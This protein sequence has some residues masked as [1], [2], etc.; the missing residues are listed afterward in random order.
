MAIPTVTNF[1]TTRIPVEG[2]STF[3]ADAS[4]VW[5][6]IP[7]VIDSMNAAIVEQNNVSDV[8]TLSEINAKT[9]ETNAATSE[10]NAKTSETNASDSA[11][12]ASAAVASLPAGT[13]DDLLI[14]TDKAWSSDKINREISSIDTSVINRPSITSP[15]DGAVDFNGDIASSPYTSSS[16]YKGTH[17]GTDWEVTTDSTFAVIDHSSYNDTVNLTQLHN[18]ADLATTTYYVRCRYI[19]DSHTSTWSTPV[20]F[21]TSAVYISTPVVTVDGE[22]TSV[23]ET[24]YFYGGAFTV[25]G[26]TDT[27]ISTDWVVKD[28]NGLVVWQSLGDTVNLTSVQVPSGVLLVSTTYTFEVTYYGATYTSTLGSTSA[29]T[30]ASFFIEGI[31]SAIITASDGLASDYF[32][33]GISV[34]DDGRTAVVGA[35]VADGT[36]LDEG[37][38]YIYT[39]DGTTVTE[40][41]ILTSPDA[42]SADGYRFGR[43]VCISKDGS[44]IIVYTY[45]YNGTYLSEGKV[46]I[47]TWDGITATYVTSVVSPDAPVA[48]YAQ[49]GNFLSL[50]YD[51]STLLIGEPGNDVLATD[52]GAVHLFSFDGTNTTSL[53]TIRASDGAA[54]DYFG[55]SGGISDAGST[56]VVGAYTADTANADQGKAYIF[57]WDGT[58]ATEKV[59][60]TASDGAASDYF[61]I[62]SEISGD[63]STV[64]I[65]AYGVDGTYLGEGKVYIYTWDGTTVTE[66]ATFSGSRAAIADNRYLGYSVSVNYSGDT[67]LIS[68]HTSDYV[69][70]NQGDAYICS[71]DG[72]TLTET[73]VINSS[74]GATGDY[75]SRDIQISN[76][77]TTAWIGAYGADTAN[78]DQGKVYIF[79]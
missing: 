39:W 38:V 52:A 49:F 62:S 36:Y 77:G 15:A 45:G 41:A 54:S 44:T 79:V 20:S 69:T 8:V 56:I 37:K 4:Y 1:D 63:S 25:N 40:A 47:Y 53:T 71:W 78:V 42:I 58:T 32:G 7:T 43:K 75:F 24:P 6:T 60:L 70:V 46:Y 26:G 23:G 65:G 73:N 3:R 55:A 67:I 35:Y 29:T 33:L 48:D 16:T 61:G 21:T 57:T 28:S 51:G 66:A 10:A 50:N 31:E 9:S 11:D 34:S 30:R 18:P 64:V 12:I 14:A 76:D 59:I 13:I 27:H 2:S 74:D 5:S 72:T 17:Y 19:S 22:P 68:A